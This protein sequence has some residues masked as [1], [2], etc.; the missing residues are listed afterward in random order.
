MMAIAATSAVRA[1]AAA[2]VTPKLADTFSSS[3]PDPKDWICEHDL[4]MLMLDG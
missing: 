2:E 4:E 1:P 3:L